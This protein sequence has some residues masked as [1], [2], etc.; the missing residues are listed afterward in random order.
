[1]LQIPQVYLDSVRWGLGLKGWNT[2]LERQN[3]GLK[4]WYAGLGEW[5]ARPR[6]WYARKKKA[7]DKGISGYLALYGA[8]SS[9]CYSIEKVLTNNIPDILPL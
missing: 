3:T 4:G 2:R 5:Y 8:V 6:K 7:R 1:M 9:K